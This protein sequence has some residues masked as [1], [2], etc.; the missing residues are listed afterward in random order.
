M[1]FLAT[2]IIRSCIPSDVRQATVTHVWL[3]RVQVHYA[4][5]AGLAVV[6]LLI[7]ITRWIAGLIERASVRLMGAKDARVAVLGE[8][9][10][11]MRQIKA[12]LWEPAFLAKVR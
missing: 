4:F 10:R 12:S 9:L 6:V 1:P 7:P 3:A 2:R 8:M 11:G 5:I